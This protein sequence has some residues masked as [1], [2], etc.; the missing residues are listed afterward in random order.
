MCDIRW[1]C[2]GMSKR[3]EMDGEPKTKSVRNWMERSRCSGCGSI[4]SKGIRTDA[5]LG[6][7]SS[8][9]KVSCRFGRETKVQCS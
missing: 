5:K 2:S 1:R 4:I 8:E 6:V 9:R 7:E 3:G